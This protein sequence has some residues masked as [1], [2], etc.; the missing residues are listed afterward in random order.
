MY[1]LDDRS[2]PEPEAFWVGGARELHDRHPAGRA[3]GAATLLRAERAGRQS[4]QVRVGRWR[5]E[6][7]LGAGEERRVQVPIDPQR[8][9]ALLTITTS[10]GFR[11][12]AVDPKSRDDRFLGVW[13]KVVPDK[14]LLLRHP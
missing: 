1:F 14:A 5:D 9:A 11:P 7:S 8:G 4:R 10:A 2:F 3:A 12:S 13:I 6:M